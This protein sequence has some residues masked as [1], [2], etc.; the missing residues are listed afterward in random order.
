[1]ITLDAKIESLLFYKGEP[2]SVNTLA[3]MLS[4]GKDEIESALL[5]LEE[6]LSDRGIELI[7][8]EDEVILTTS[9]EMSEAIDAIRK[10]EL[11]KDLSK[12]S[13]ETLAIVMYKNGST[14]SEIDYIRGVNSSFI[15]RN[16]LIRGL[17]EKIPDPKDQRR[18]IYKPTFELL[19]FMGVSRIENIPEWNEINAVLSNEIAKSVEKTEEILEKTEDL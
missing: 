14:R 10:E 13:L 16:L 9:R 1:M 19:S 15:L 4:V 11:T 5:V 8:K 18:L 17:I 2:L 12:A 6:K 3:K 7:R